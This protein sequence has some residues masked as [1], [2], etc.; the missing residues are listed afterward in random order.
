MSADI[1]LLG[2]P[3]MAQC[4]RFVSRHKPKSPTQWLALLQQIP[5]ADLDIDFYG[6]G[7]AVDLLEEKIANILGKEKALFVH[8]GMVG[9][10]SALL[11][12]SRQKQSSSIALHPQSHLQIDEALAYQ[13]LG[14][15]QA[16]LFGKPGRAFDRA[17]IELLPDKLAAVSIELPTRRAGFVLPTWDDTLYLRDFCRSS[18][19]PLHMDGA[20]LWESAAYW[21]RDY[22]EVATLADSVYVSLYKSLGAMAGG[23][24]AGEA[25][26]I[27]SLKPWIT[28]F[29][30][31]IHTVF[32]Y[33]LSALWGLD[34]YLPRIPEF[35]QRAGKLASEIG[36]AFGESSIVKPVQSNAILVELPVN[37]KRLGE[38]ALDFAKNEHCWLFDRLI[39]V[40]ENR[41]HFELQVGDALDDWSDQ[42]LIEMFKLLLTRA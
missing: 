29:G 9:Q 42:E 5:E 21:N 3:L 31:N 1:A 14:H 39:A 10:L 37:A 11:Q 38:L 35:Q 4:Q 24:I 2:H 32:C 33:V 20:R 40:D 25:D 28:R 15:L 41:C 34:H 13:E 22:H 27:D 17:D 12:W 23:I 26:F 6:R 8:K 19:T 16:C 36:K 18:Q 30:G 7:P